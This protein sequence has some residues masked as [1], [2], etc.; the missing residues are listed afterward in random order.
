MNLRQTRPRGTDARGILLMELAVSMSIFAL[1][2]SFLGFALL[3]S[4]RS[5]CD[6]I[7]DAELRQEMQIAA[8]RIVESAQCSDHIGQ[9]QRGVYE[10]RQRTRNG[11][12]ID[13]YWLTNDSLVLKAVTLP[14]TGSFDGAGVRIETFSIREDARRPRLY[15]IEM[16]GVSTVTGRAYSLA[17]AVYLREGAGGT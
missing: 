15:H 3:W 6:G 4:W 2:M 9:R 16:T 17:T 13:L 10:M 14:I 11:E 7:A 12:P 5:Y 8:A 1:L